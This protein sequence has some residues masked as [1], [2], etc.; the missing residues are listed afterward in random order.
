MASTKSMLMR[1][2]Y[3]NVPEK[4]PDVP[5]L[6]NNLKWKC[7]IFCAAFNCLDTDFHLAKKDCSV[8]I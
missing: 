5:T 2:S 1:L 6:F 8:K 4:K 7:K 3:A